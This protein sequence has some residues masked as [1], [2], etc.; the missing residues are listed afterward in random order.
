MI[1]GTSAK[2]QMLTITPI[3]VSLAGTDA[4]FRLC[5]PA[6]RLSSRR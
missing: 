4:A 1:C 6:K 2:K 3:V 5:A